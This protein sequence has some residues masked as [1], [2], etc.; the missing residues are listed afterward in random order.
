MM[1]ALAT[2]A[3]KRTWLRRLR[4]PGYWGEFALHAL[5]GGFA[6]L[7]P[8]LAFVL[9]REVRQA[10]TGDGRGRPSRSTGWLDFLTDLAAY[11]LGSMTFAAFA[12]W[13]IVRRHLGAE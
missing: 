6:W 2:P 10:A 7:P 3:Q 1:A 9:Y 8:V 4:E 11:V 12:A 5:L 13:W